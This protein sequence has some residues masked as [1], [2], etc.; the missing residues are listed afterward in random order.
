MSLDQ[1]GDSTRT[2]SAARSLLQSLK[3]RVSEMLAHHKLRI[4]LER[5][6]IMPPERG[7]LTR[8]HVLFIGPDLS[9]EDGK[10]LL[11]ISSQST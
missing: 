1:S 4:S 7:D 3:P 8:A 11:A 9:S 5:L 2:L 10:R 6:D